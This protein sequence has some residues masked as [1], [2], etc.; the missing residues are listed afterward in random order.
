MKSFV[1]AAIAI[2]GLA[3]G[4]QAAVSITF[5][6]GGSAAFNAPIDSGVLVAD[7]GTP[8]GNLQPY[9]GPGVFSPG[10]G[11]VFVTNVG[12]QAARPAF[13]ST[14]GYAAVFNGGSFAINFAASQVFSFTLGSLDPSNNVR[15]LFAN[16][17]FIDYLG[18]VLNGAL[19]ENGN[20]T[21]NTQN[22]RVIF[23]AQGG[24]S[25][26]GAVFTS[27]QNSFEFDNIV[28]AVPEPGTWAMMILGFGIAGWQ[29]RARRKPDG[30]LAIA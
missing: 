29:L 11:G 3:T 1:L 23:D 16:N 27:G 28:T 14:G 24:S 20:Q 25:I 7:F 9:G 19:T 22:G 8:A 15:L 30:K 12:G 4:A 2:G 26:V 18:P 21:V 5:N 10:G 17:T 13:G 6:P